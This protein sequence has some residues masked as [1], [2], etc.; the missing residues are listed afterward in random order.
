MWQKLC[1]MLLESIWRVTTAFLINGLASTS[2]AE[3]L[4]VFK[5]C[6][7]CPEMIELPLGEFMMGAPEDEFRNNATVFI[8]D[9]AF[10]AAQNDPAIV[11]SEGPR[12]RVTI[13][14][15]ISIGRNEVTYSE[16]MSCV[17]DGGCNGYIP[18]DEV[19]QAGSDGAVERALGDPRFI[20]TPSEANIALAMSSPDLLRISGTYPVLYI[21]YL[22]AQSYVEWLN[23]KTGSN[24]YR[25]PSEAEWEYAARANTTT[26]FPQG[27]EPKPEQVNISGELTELYLQEPRPDLRT[28]G[29]PVPVGELDSAN[30]W[31]LRH[32]SGNAAEITLSCYSDQYV[33]WSTS[34]EWLSQSF[35]EHCDRVERGGS[36]RSPMSEARPAFRRAIEE[37]RRSADNGFRIVKVLE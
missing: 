34:T 10:S 13:D 2:I 18:D 9:G 20:H 28:L 32:M 12:H 23:L 15:A 25:L 16:W 11:Q 4:D 24:A 37:D 8:Q 30:A 27:F 3:P 31:G 29:Y 22:D 1:N 17:Q 26:R 19:A 6:D 14:T 21:S 5:D 7:V 36:Y 35:L 33:G